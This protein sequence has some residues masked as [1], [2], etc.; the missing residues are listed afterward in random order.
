MYL[1]EKKSILYPIGILFFLTLVRYKGFDSDAAL[2]LLQ[3]VHYLYPERFINDVPF[4]FGNQ[5]SFS[6]FSPVI[7]QIF[8]VLGVNKGGFLA[9]LL[10]LVAWSG[11][12]ITFLNKWMEKFGLKVWSILLILVFFSLLLNRDYGSGCF[13]LPV[14]E[15]YLVARVLSEVL[16]L[17][18]LAFIFCKNKYV[19]LALFVLSSLI[20]PLMGGW[21]LPLWLFFH[22]PKTRI[23]VVVFSLVSPV[24]GFLH[25][26]RFDFYPPDWRPLYYTPGL[27]EFVSYS[28]LVLF[29]FFM[30]RKLN[31]PLLSKFAISLFWV[32]LIGFSLQFVGCWSAHLLLYQAQPFRVQWLCYL[33]VIP[34]F[35]I[36]LQEI[37]Y[38][39]RKLSV[40]DYIGM[41][42]GVAAV[43]N[44]QWL[45]FFF[46]VACGVACLLWMVKINGFADSWIKVMFVLCFVFMVVNSMTESFVQL[47]L[48]QNLVDASRAISWIFVP[49]K[50]VYVE[51]ILLVVL[52]FICV[53]QRSLWF[54]LAF[55]LA[56]CNSELKMVAIVAIVLYLVPDIKTL[57]RKVLIAL[58]STVSFVG[59]LCSSD[60]FN[61]FQSVVVQR[62]PVIGIV[63]LLFVFAL[64]LWMLVLKCSANA[65]KYLV[66]LILFMFLLT[67][68]N[69]CTWDARDEQQ[70]RRERQM[71]SFFKTPL[72]PQVADRGKMLFVVEYEA[73][74]QSRI[75]FLT[76][77]Y[78]DESI[79]VGEV[80]Y[81][82]QYVES[83]RRRSILLRGDSILADMTNFKE[84]IYLIYQNP[85]TLLARVNYLCHAG[86]ITH[87]VTDGVNSTLPKLDSAYLDAREIAVYLYGCPLKETL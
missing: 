57:F 11:C 45:W 10:M 48:E 6:F 24:S 80:L 85:D 5:D 81:K 53:R 87:F 67:I 4:M 39:Q 21:A 41:L 26:W 47:A 55:A 37:L 71:D 7:A 49:Q 76:G 8:N 50:L 1:F 46:V 61:P 22:Y 54:A 83:N 64:C 34:V 84:N 38:E 66:P 3:V 42:L 33:P 13:Y 17:A 60:S 31:K 68:W 40:V 32:S 19:S 14:M 65:N 2:Y 78:A 15:P 58:A 56:C 59:L 51:K 86:E 43:A 75:N 9:T 16:V 74:I 25:L 82:G 12:A 72:F 23:L 62:F 52:S 35:A 79:F 70:I 20:H 27:E 44:Q 30:Y 29:W 28:G 18:G 69:V 73:P 63:F 77:A 36:Y